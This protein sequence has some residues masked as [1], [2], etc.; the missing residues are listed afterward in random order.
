MV[1]LD[2][3]DT[4]VKFRGRDEVIAPALAHHVQLDTTRGVPRPRSGR[5]GGVCRRDRAV[6]ERGL[7]PRDETSVDFAALIAPEDEMSLADRRV[8]EA[9]GPPRIPETQYVSVNCAPSTARA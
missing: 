4:R 7:S 3:I 8:N 6:L 2:L 9:V 5:H 1:N